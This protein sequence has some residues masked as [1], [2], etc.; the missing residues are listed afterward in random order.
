[1]ILCVSATLVVAGLITYAVLRG[2]SH[3]DVV[4]G[5]FLTAFS[6]YDE[7]SDFLADTAGETYY[8][9]SF[10]ESLDGD[11]S[12]TKVPYSTTNIQVSGVD[13]QDVAKTDG[14][15]MFIVARNEVTIVK[16]HPADGMEVVATLTVADVLGS[17][18]D[19]DVR[20]DVSGLFLFEDRLVVV[21]TLNSYSYWM[22]YLDESEYSNEDIYRDRSG[23]SVF[24]IED[25][26]NPRLVH[27]FGV[28]GN[29]LATRM[30]GDVVYLVA[31]SNIFW[32]DS[33]CFL[34]RSWS[35]DDPSDLSVSEVFHDAGTKASDAFL[36]LM[37]LDVANGRHEEISVVTG[38]ASTVYMSLDSLYVSFQKWSGSLLLVDGEAV[39]EREST[40]M[41]TIHKISV[42]GLSMAPVASGDVKGWLLNQFSMD[43][44]DGLLR[45]A[46]TTSW[47]TPENCVYVLSSNLSAVGSLEGLAPTERIY[48][49]RF[50]DDTLYLVTFLQVDPLFVIDLRD[51]ASPKVLGELKIPGFSSY[52]HP[53][54]DDHLIGIGR[55]DGSVKISLFDI[56]TPANPVE[57]DSYLVGSNSYTEASYD[58]KAVLFY[59]ERGMLVI[60]I[61]T[62]DLN[63]LTGLYDTMCQA[64]VFN[65]S[66][67][68]GVSLWG[69]VDHSL[70]DSHNAVM[71]ALYIGETLY[72][73]SSQLVKA[74]SLIDLSEEGTL[75][76]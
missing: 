27:S 32:Y 71:R 10:Y 33:E 21:W 16:A 70:D 37:S 15:H 12:G 55:E 51:P 49:A 14:E 54:G 66:E 25:I 6:S 40:T 36:N 64:W 43:E 59:Q 24:D 68:S 18:L 46:T 52:L 34:P 19:E 29:L 74:N 45:V 1:M 73:I 7:L 75:A 63:E 50:I 17:E 62:Y 60:P 20:I 8:D 38:F 57:V 53:M 61:T 58:H 13:E 3:D 65:V 9:Y 69:I 41:T 30:I 23:L 5:G 56:S 42:D 11:S 26:G 39:A 22:L 72:T 47:T 31:Q 48:A 76:Y 2:P 35:G 44:K 67:E 4:A 28:S